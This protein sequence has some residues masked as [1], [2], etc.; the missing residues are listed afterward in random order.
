MSSSTV[1]TR[2]ETY[3]L[4]EAMASGSTLGN[5]TRSATCMGAAT[6]SSETLSGTGPDWT[7]TPQALDAYTCTVTNTAKSATLVIV[8]H[9]APPVDVNGDGLTDA[10][11]QISY[12]FTVSN[13][14]EVTMADLAVT[15][16]KVGAVSCPSATLAP[17]TGQICTADNP[18]TVTTADV[19]NGSVDNSATVTGTPPASSSPVTSAPS[20]TSTTATAPTPRLTIAKSA[21]PSTAAAAAAGTTLTY[22]FLVTNTGNVPVDTVGVTEG[23]F[24]GSGTFSP[25][26][27]PSAAAS[28]APGAHTTCT[29]SYSLTQADVDAGSVSN[30]A[31][32]DGTPRG[33]ATA[34]TSAPDTATVTIPAAPSLSVVKSASPTTAHAAGQTVSYTFVVSNTGNVTIAGVTVDE[35]AFSG[36]GTT[37]AISCPGAA[38]ALAPGADVTCAA[39][40]TLT[41]ADVDTGTVTNT[42]TVSGTAPG[43]TTPSRPSE[44]STATVTVAQAPSLSLVKSAEP[45]AV[46]AVGDQIGYT[47]LVTNNGNVTL[48]AVEVAEG[49]FSGAGAMSAVSCPSQSAT[50]APGAQL[51]CTATYAV[52][53]ADLDQGSVS[54]TA[55]ANGTAPSGAA[56][57]SLPS[58]TVVGSDAEGILRVTKRAHVGDGD[59]DEVNDTGDRIAWSRSV[60]HTGTATVSAISVLDPTAGQVTCTGTVLAPG[61]SLTCTVPAHTVTDLDVAQGSVVNTASATGTGSN[62]VVTSSVATATVTLAGDTG[63]TGNTGD[64]GDSGKPG[65]PGAA[66]SAL[67]HTGVDQGLL[68]AGAGGALA[69]LVGLVLSLAAHSRPRRASATRD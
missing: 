59:S 15:D 33:S 60:A 11:D 7:F 56:V 43:S 12:S 5:Y 26:V 34:V 50:L 22:S 68:Y 41:Q 30:T 37:P 54:N 32:A 49:E 21:A 66:P 28:L 48:T 16:S 57:S 61:E 24:T 40:Y 8:K 58:T 47:F 46:S 3:T 53:Q 64:T 18:Y 35:V 62:G 63:D 69:V 1:V 25:V 9:D 52:T 45:S 19:V 31:T 10:G 51:E 44:S 4:T 6:G 36:S 38:A 17:G 29:A 27:C 65:Q 42:A 20:T 2:G 23:T 13:T 55:T 39:T 14:G 67:P